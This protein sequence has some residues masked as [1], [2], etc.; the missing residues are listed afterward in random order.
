M[1]QLP[2]VYHCDRARLRRSTPLPLPLP[3]FCALPL[4]T[5]QICATTWRPFEAEIV[6]TQYKRFTRALSLPSHCLSLSLLL[7]LAFSALEI[8]LQIERIIC[9]A[10]AFWQRDTPPSVPAP[11]PASSLLD[12][13]CYLGLVYIMVSH[14]H[15]HTRSDNCA[16]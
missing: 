16:N 2:H 12:S 8:R 13:P 1:R 7:S 11:S 9:S 3:P 6:Q 15:T 14:T 4:G 5:G 10:T